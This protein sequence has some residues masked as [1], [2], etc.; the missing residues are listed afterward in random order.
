MKSILF[1][2]GS[3]L[4]LS[5]AMAN[6]N[7]ADIQEKIEKK[8]D[9]LEKGQGKTQKVT[10]PWNTVDQREKAFWSS[11]VRTYDYM[12]SFGLSERYF[13]MYEAIRFSSLGHPERGPELMKWINR[14]QARLVDRN[15]HPRFFGKWNEHIVDVKNKIEELNQQ[16]PVVTTAVEGDSKELASF[17]NEL[18]QDLSDIKTTTEAQPSLEK[19]NTDSGNTLILIGACAISLLAGLSIPR[20]KKTIV[21]YKTVPAPVSAPVTAQAPVKETEVTLPSLPLEAF[22]KDP[23]SVVLEEECRKIIDDNSHLFELSQVKIHHGLRSPFNTS[24]Y[25][26]S[27]QLKEAINWLLK[28]T[29]AI[30][31]TNGKKASYLEW[32]CREK[33]GRVSLDFVLHGLECDQKALYLNTLIEGDGSAPAHFSRSE[34]ALEGHLPSIQFKTGNKRTTI[35]LGLNAGKHQLSH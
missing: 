18:K 1:L 26:S 35:S 16:R 21:K 22:D 23:L 8:L 2:T 27:E 19:E 31:N 3:F 28:G 17:L 11:V 30:A 13:F 25:A 24:V 15:I 5:S 33:E 6:V 32:N 20:K 4:V 29:L 7:I 14:E 34:I 10:V 12:K 9:S